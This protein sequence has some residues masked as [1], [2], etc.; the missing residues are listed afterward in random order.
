[1]STE[2]LEQLKKYLA[3]DPADPFLHYALAMEFISLEQHAKA[4][5]NLRQLIETHPDYLPSYYQCGKEGFHLSENSI[6]ADIVNRGIALAKIKG[7]RHAEAELR[8][9]LDEYMDE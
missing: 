3:E 5:E 6:A 4:F 8:S 1:M 7:N 9:L 2:R